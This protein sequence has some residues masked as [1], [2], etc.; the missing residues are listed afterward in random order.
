MSFEEEERLV[1]DSGWGRE[2]GE[3]GSFDGGGKLGGMLVKI[4][5]ESREGGS[6][7]GI[8]GLGAGGMDEKGNTI[9]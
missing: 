5:G 8:I 9:S 4:S 7:V 3:E 6:G 1:G 2:V